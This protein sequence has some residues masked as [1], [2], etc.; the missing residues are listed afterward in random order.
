LSTTVA[1]PT[2]RTAWIRGKGVCELTIIIYSHIPPHDRRMHKVQQ[3]L[4]NRALVRDIQGALHGRHGAYVELWHNVPPRLS[5]PSARFNMLVLEEK[6]RLFCQNL[7]PGIV[8][9][10]ADLATLEAHFANLGTEQ[11]VSPHLA[12]RREQL[13]DF[14]QVRS[15]WL[16]A[17][18]MVHSL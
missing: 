15:P 5:Q 13:L 4:L 3:D 6:W 18:L 14:R 9:G 17:F 8:R 2:S 11:S 1:P 7:L 16:A 10:C 12:C